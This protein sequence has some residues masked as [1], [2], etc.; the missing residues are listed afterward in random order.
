MLLQEILLHEAYYWFQVYF[1]NIITV[2]LII[3]NSTS[4]WKI[5][6]E[7]HILPL[8]SFSISKVFII[9]KKQS[10]FNNIYKAIVYR[11]IYTIQYTTRNTANRPLSSSL[12][13]SAMSNASRSMK[14]KIISSIK[15]RSP[16]QNQ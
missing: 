16:R 5:I 14:L 6:F 3:T 13:V 8:M 2:R 7:K 11:E 9:F 1:K 15:H 12:H 4:F 10:I